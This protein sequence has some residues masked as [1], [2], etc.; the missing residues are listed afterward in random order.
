[1]HVHFIREKGNSRFMHNKLC[2]LCH[3]ACI[4]ISWNVCDKYNI[5]GGSGV[6]PR[7]PC[8]SIY[9]RPNTNR[10]IVGPGLGL[11]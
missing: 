7:I 2:I 8:L 5:A 10:K 1:M 9:L 11:Y 4:Q 3:G 6:A